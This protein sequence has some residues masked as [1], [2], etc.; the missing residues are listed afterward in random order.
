M[1]LMPRSLFI[2]AFLLIVASVTVCFK[3][4]NTDFER[5][6]EIIVMRNIG[7]EILLSSGDSS[8][9]VLPVDKTGNNQYRIRFENSLKFMP[10]SVVRIIRQAVKAN[11]LPSDYITQVVS[12][13]ILFKVKA[14]MNK[15]IFRS[16]PLKVTA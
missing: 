14:K 8:S 3:T 6:R 15:V 13:T 12:Y 16:H 10:D 9:R 7:H 11:N 5:A 4:D 1:K 2:T